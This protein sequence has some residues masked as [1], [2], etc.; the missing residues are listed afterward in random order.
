LASK[1]GLGVYSMPTRYAGLIW[2]YSGVTQGYMSLFIW[3]PAKQIIISVAINRRQG[4][5][6]GLLMPGQLLVEQIFR[7]LD[8]VIDENENEY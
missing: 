5:N 4:G 6:Y 2:W 1:Y 8:K 3:A 7:Q